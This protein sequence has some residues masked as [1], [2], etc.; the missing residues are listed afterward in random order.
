MSMFSAVSCF[1]A[2]PNPPLPSEHSLIKNPLGLKSVSFEKWWRTF[3]IRCDWYSFHSC[4]ATSVVV[5]VAASL[6]LQYF[7]P[8]RVDTVWHQPKF[9]HRRDSAPPSDSNYRP[10]KGR[11]V[12][13]PEKGTLLSLLDINICRKVT[14]CCDTNRPFIAATH[15]LGLHFCTTS[16]LCASFY[17]TDTVMWML[18]TRLCHI[19]YS[20]CM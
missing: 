12:P 1:L 16:M 4:A 19:F 5:V 20:R 18:D 17:S 7:E 3:P 14:G 8:L 2:V 9:C 6:W 10:G 11:E 13:G 15:V